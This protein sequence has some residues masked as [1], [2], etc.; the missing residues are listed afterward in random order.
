MRQEIEK[1]KLWKIFLERMKLPP[2]A[3][4]ME[5]GGITGSI[6]RHAQ[7]VEEYRRESEQAATV[8]VNIADSLGYDLKLPKSG[9]N[10]SLLDFCFGKSLEDEGE[11]AGRMVGR[12]CPNC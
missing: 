11:K 5:T 1:R 7:R 12:D 3:C 8:C 10:A 2:I 4:E 9:N 6:A